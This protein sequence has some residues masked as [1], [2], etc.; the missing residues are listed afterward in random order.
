M[1]QSNFITID[2]DVY[3]TAVAVIAAVAIAFA[4]AFCCCFLHCSA[5][6]ALDD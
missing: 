1:L 6:V 5:A 2:V 3:N 4:V